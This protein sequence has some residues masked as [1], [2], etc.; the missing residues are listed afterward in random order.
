[1]VKGLTVVTMVHEY[2][3]KFGSEV[4]VD[5]TGDSHDSVLDNG[6]MPFGVTEFKC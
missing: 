1:M 5:L 2:S 6:D 4:E 3:M